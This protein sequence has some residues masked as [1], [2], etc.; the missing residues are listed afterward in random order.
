MDYKVQSQVQ[1]LDKWSKL[2][3]K[4]LKKSGH[5]GKIQGIHTYDILR[6]P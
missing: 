2:T 4:L 5:E 1:K 6:N 3:D